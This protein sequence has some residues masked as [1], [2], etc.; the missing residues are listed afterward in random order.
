MKKNKK[1][2]KGNEPLHLRLP[3]DVLDKV[4]YLAEKQNRNKSNMAIHLIKE[5][6][7]KY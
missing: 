2:V 3:Q 5:S 4:K 6:L 7:T 1:E